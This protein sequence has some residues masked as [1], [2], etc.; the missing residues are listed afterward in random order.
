MGYFPTPPR[1][2]G[3]VSGFAV[4][5][6]TVLSYGTTTTGVQDPYLGTGA[7]NFNGTDARLTYTRFGLGQFV[8]SI[9]VRTTSTDTTS[10]YSGNPAQVIFGDHSNSVACQSGLTGGKPEIRRFN[11]SAWETA[12]HTQEV[13][14]GLWHKVTYLYDGAGT[15][16]IAVDD[17][18]FESFSLT[19]TASGNGGCDTI[20]AGYTD[21]TNY[22][23]FFDG[24]LFLPFI[25]S[26]REWQTFYV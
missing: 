20:G 2:P 17:A 1:E 8:A 16:K 13:N 11:G 26:G 7:R 9:W 21:G 18:G 14:D 5:T 4:A 10:A 25:Q 22:A 19:N 15:A 3:G 23:D 24:D 12:T 6:G